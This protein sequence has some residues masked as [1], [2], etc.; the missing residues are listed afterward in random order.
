MRELKYYVACTVDRFIAAEDGSFDAF[1]MEGEHLADLNT[2][3]PETVPGHARQAAGVQGCPNRVFDAVLMGRNT[4]ETGSKHGVTSPYP[5]LEQY[6]F[7]RTMKA[8]PDPAVELVSRDELAMVRRLKQSAGKDIWL[9][10]GG[11]LAAALFAEIDELVLK[12]N[13]VVLGAGIPLFAGAVTRTPL[14]LTGVRSYENGVAL[15]RYRLRHR[16]R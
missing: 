8:S 9:C 12:V 5:H 13:P 4:Y 7:S 1:L 3:M 11:T 14:E 10:G 16:S 6:L 2:E 15:M